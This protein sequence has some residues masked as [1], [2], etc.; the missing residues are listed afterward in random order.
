MDFVGEV[1]TV[2]PN[3]VNKRVLIK[4]VDLTSCEVGI[5]G[6]VAAD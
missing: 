3:K 5:R 6:I 4:G 2:L 1:D